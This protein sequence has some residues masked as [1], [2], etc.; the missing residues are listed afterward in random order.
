MNETAMSAMNTCD[1]IEFINDIESVVVYISDTSE[2]WTS[3]DNY[4]LSIK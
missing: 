2:T 3:V 1:I 4:Q